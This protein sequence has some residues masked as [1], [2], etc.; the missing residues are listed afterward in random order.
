MNNVITHN[1]FIK[2]NIEAYI[3]EKYGKKPE[4][5][6][7]INLLWEKTKKLE[8]RLFRFLPIAPGDIERLIDLNESLEDFAA[9][10][11]AYVQKC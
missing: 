1:T 5:Q 11:K 9:F 3:L 4:H 2:Y 6:R 10:R 8:N 7:K